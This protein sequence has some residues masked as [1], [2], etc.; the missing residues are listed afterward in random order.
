MEDIV[1]TDLVEFEFDLSPEAQER[2]AQVR[3]E[4]EPQVALLKRIRS[5]LGM[6]QAELAQALEVT[7]S[8]VSKIEKRDDPTLSVLARM[9]ESKGGKLRLQ[10]ETAEGDELKF[11]V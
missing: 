5:A 6:S 1:V 11:A 4:I 9:I 7:Q 2:V 10:I 3:R 8:N